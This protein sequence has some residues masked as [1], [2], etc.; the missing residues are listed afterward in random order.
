M[1][2][3]TL[4]NPAQTMSGKTHHK[5]DG[6]FYVT[7]SGKQFYRKRDESYHKIRSPKQRWVGLS[8]AYAHAEMQ[9]RFSTPEQVAQMIEAWKSVHK[10]G[11]N[12]KFFQTAHSWQFAQLQLEWQTEHPYETWYAGYLQSVSD[13]ADAVTSAEH[14]SDNMLRQ[15]I[16]VLQAQLDALKSQL[17]K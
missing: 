12:G 3:V 13:Q 6:Y 14:V 2:R 15:Q 11:V 7:E 16:A 17:S 8:F 10:L 5:E 4:T 1:A 9:K